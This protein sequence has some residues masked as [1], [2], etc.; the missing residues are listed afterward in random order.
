M[1]LD[2]IVHCL[3][4]TL[5]YDLNIKYFRVNKEN[6]IYGNSEVKLKKDKVH[7]IN[8]K[9]ETMTE[10]KTLHIFKEALFQMK[11]FELGLDVI[12]FY[13]FVIGEDNEILYKLK[14]IDG[15]ILVK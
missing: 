8:I 10:A 7:K 4:I 15:T 1:E 12:D 13:L 6:I 3:N 11:H 2:Y 14:V 9:T 5:T